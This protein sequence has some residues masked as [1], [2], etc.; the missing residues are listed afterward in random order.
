[1]KIEESTNYD[2]SKFDI[3]QQNSGERSPA[4]DPNSPHVVVESKKG[5]KYTSKPT[6]PSQD[7]EQ[8]VLRQI[9]EK[10]TL[11]IDSSILPASHRH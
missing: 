1:M 2:R 8:I 11:K 9:K 7:K 5:Y 4:E 6:S 3:K 10:R